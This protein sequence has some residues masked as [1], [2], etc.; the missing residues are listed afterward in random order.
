[1]TAEILLPRTGSPDAATAARLRGAAEALVVLRDRPPTAR[2]R[3]CRHG[4]ALLLRHACPADWRRA[5]FP[6]PWTPVPRGHG[7][8]LLSDPAV[9]R[10]A[11][12]LM[13]LYCA[14]LRATEQRAHWTR[15]AQFF[16]PYLPASDPEL[17]RLRE[18]AE[19]L[20]APRPHWTSPRSGS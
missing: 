20:R 2:G 18:R 12:A 13:E 7:T 19:R 15:L 3:A 9:L 4:L 14:D 6:A 8:V 1:M 10:L 16:A 5:G 11:G 17:T